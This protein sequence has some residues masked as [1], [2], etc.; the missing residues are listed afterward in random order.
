MEACDSIAINLDW[1][2]LYRSSYVKDDLE[3]DYKFFAELCA[4]NDLVYPKVHLGGVDSNIKITSTCLVS[5]VT[6]R[7]LMMG[8]APQQAGLPLSAARPLGGGGLI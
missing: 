1:V 6:D 5:E 3:L 7:H 2:I 8:Q 4:A